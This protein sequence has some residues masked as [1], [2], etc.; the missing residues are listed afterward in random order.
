MYHSFHQLP[1]LAAALVR[2]VYLMVDS[3]RFLGI[4]LFRV[5]EFRHGGHLDTLSTSS[6]LSGLMIR[7]SRRNGRGWI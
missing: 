1:L 7:S 5:L 3:L 2:T 6:A 4:E